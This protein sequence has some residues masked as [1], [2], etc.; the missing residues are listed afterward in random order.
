MQKITLKTEARALIIMLGAIILS[1]WS[2]PQL[3]IKVA[4]HWNFQ[5]QV[6]G[7]STSLFHALLFPGLIMIMY[8]TFLVMPYF[9]PK[10]ERY[11]E[12]ESVYRLMRDAIMFV[13]LGVFAAA[14]FYD[15]NYPINVAAI[16][17]GLVGALMIVMGNYFGKLKRNWFIGLRT[18]WSLSSENVWNKTHRLG[19]RLFIVWGF[20]I[21]LAPW[22]SAQL[23]IS[24]L[25]IGLGIILF[26]VYLYSYLLYRQE[27][28]AHKSGKNEHI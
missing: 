5:G 3:P 21:I 22:L 10:K 16:V 14:T 24:I 8:F 11:L 18:P 17:S 2:Y 4:S 25:L 6:D 19:G 20:L 26:G 28:L 13:L 15:L 9:D 27:Q 1:Y 12:F 23:A 7:W